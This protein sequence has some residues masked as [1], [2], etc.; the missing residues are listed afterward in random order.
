MLPRRAGRLT[1]AGRAPIPAARRSDSVGGGR[2]LFDGRLP[3]RAPFDGPSLGEPGDAGSGA[4]AA[5]PASDPPLGNGA[6]DRRTEAVPGTRRVVPDA[7]PGAD[8]RLSDLAE[9]PYGG[10][11]SAALS[12]LGEADRTGTERLEA[13]RGWV[14]LV[15]YAESRLFTTMASIVDAVVED[16][17]IDLDRPTGLGEAAE[18][19]EIAATLHLT[20]RAAEH[21]L[22]FALGRR[23]R[24]PA[25]EH[26]RL[27]RRRATVFL[28][29]TATCRS[30]FPGCRMPAVDCD[31]D[32]TRPWAE[33]GRTAPGNLQPLCR[34]HHV[35]HH[36]GR[37]Y[38][39]LDDGRT[40]W[41]SPLGRVTDVF[42]D[43]TSRPPP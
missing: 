21:D 38:V 2:Y 26:G 11:L 16:Q 9:M 24:L 14:R 10:F 3:W 13:M 36:R 12:T 34:H 37:R 35:R 25:L 6:E 20:R 5:D 7:G 18:S 43:A 30:V 28:R 19:V 40:R 32:H 23:R 39:L 1:R 15:A 17:A 33:G 41:P 31:L 42:A 29:G 27:D 4:G 22:E 8:S